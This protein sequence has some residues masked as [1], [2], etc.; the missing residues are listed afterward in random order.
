MAKKHSQCIY[1][2]AGMSVTEVRLEFLQGK[3]GNKD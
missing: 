1:S 2:S 3:G